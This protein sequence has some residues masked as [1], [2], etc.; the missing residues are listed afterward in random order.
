MAR[1]KDK[2]D[3]YRKEN[4]K[5][6]DSDFDGD[7]EHIIGVIVSRLSG[8]NKDICSGLI[9]GMNAQPQG[10]V[11][12][13]SALESVLLTTEREMWTNYANLLQTAHKFALENFGFNRADMESIR[14]EI[15]SIA[16]QCDDD[17][18]GG[19]DRMA[20][21]KAAHKAKAQ[22]V[23][24]AEGLNSRLVRA[25]VNGDADTV[26]AVI[27]DGATVELVKAFVMSGMVDLP[28]RKQTAFLKACGLS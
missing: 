21:A 5:T 28:K 22:T 18:R 2:I 15:L 1:T 4:G 16:D 11:Q 26:K 3:D 25:A 20:E 19:L 24:A 17:G 10:G 27:A 6:T 23:A 9:H 7:P 8:A 12:G 13:S 14:A